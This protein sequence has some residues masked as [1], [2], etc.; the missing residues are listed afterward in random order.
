MEI[1]M[2]KLPAKS[3]NSLP[4]LIREVGTRGA[5][6]PGFRSLAIGNPA[7]AAIPVETIRE[8]AREVIEGDPMLIM[9]YGPANGYEKLR[10]LT[11]ERLREVK[12]LSSENQEILMMCG[13]GQGLGL[14]PRTICEEG[15]EVYTDEY[16]FTNALN[17]IRN[18]GC[19]PVGISMDEE[20]MIPEALEKA[21][22]SGKGKYIYVIPNFQNPTGITMSLERRKAVYE[23]AHK[24]DLYIYE[25]D[26]Y[27]EL[28]FK[29]ED[30]PTIKSMDVDDRVIYAG[31]YSKI[32]SA[33]L[34]VGYLFGNAGLIKV[35]QTVKNGSDGQSLP[36]LT[37]LV[38][39]NSLKKL[40]MQSYIQ[41][42]CKL[43]GKKCEA[44]LRGLK[45]TC[46]GD[47]RILEP[48]GGMFVW[49]ILPERIPVE[50]YFEKCLE[51]AVGVV[52]SKAFAAD[53]NHPGNC[54]RLNFT[55]LPEEEL[56][57]T[58]EIIGRLTK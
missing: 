43:Y 1:N 12:H 33:G 52:Q 18:A 16:A 25:D 6:I 3:V 14:F 54:V 42:I 27:G 45:R 36:M 11:V 17:G 38:V 35:M 51:N 13:S 22:S 2:K 46:A 23:I 58:G 4:N 20:G 31:S 41:E 47:V 24:Y 49:M 26:P 7:A 8:A 9:Q 37:Q 48:E 53:Q 57:R 50:E 56:E 32:L 30:I 19:K 28:R 29:G 40:D 15:D 44:L 55:F 34:R 10:Q 39:Y 5:S 21:A